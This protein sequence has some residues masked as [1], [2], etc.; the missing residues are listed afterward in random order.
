MVSNS[1]YILQQFSSDTWRSYHSFAFH[2]PHS[3]CIPICLFTFGPIASTAQYV[4]VCILIMSCVKY[5]NSKV[6]PRSKKVLILKPRCLLGTLDGSACPPRFDL[7]KLVPEEV[8]ECPK[9]PQSQTHQMAPYFLSHNLSSSLPESVAPLHR[10]SK[11][12]WTEL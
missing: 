7:S 1:R 4:H 6:S 10:T 2:I 5:S 11:S 9:Q 3:A 8:L 12:K